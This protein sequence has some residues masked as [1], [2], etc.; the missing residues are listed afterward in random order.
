MDQGAGPGDYQILVGNE[1]CLVTELL[2]EYLTFVPPVDEPDDTGL[3]SEDGGK[4]VR[5]SRAGRGAGQ[6]VS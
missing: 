1:E 5:V 4:R 6:W 3:H 2:S